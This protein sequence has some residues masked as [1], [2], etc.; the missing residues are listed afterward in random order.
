MTQQATLD[1]PESFEDNDAPGGGHV[2]LGGKPS[3]EDRRDD[4]RLDTLCGGRRLSVPIDRRADTIEHSIA[5]GD[6]SAILYD[7]E[8]LD[9]A[10]Q[11]ALAEGRS[12]DPE[13][14][15][16]VNYRAWHRKTS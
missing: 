8:P 15:S 10:E 7:D 14:L 3:V 1:H 12:A 13:F 11:K 16:L 6:E 9:D 5:R 4:R 2:V